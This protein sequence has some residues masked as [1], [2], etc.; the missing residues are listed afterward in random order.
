MPLLP[1]RAVA[2]CQAAPRALKWKAPQGFLPVGW[3][4]RWRGGRGLSFNLA[5]L[6]PLVLLKEARWRQLSTPAT[7]GGSPCLLTVERGGGRKSTV[8]GSRF[9]SAPSALWNWSFAFFFFRTPRRRTASLKGNEVSCVPHGAWGTEIIKAMRFPGSSQCLRWVLIWGRRARS[10]D[11]FQSA[12]ILYLSVR[13]MSAGP[14]GHAR[15]GVRIAVGAGSGL[16]VSCVV[17]YLFVS[18]RESAWF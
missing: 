3:C 7:A 17:A 12:S 18:E 9:L 15:L 8:L 5:C 13:Q 14:G 6:L 4:P 2:S 11:R 1:Q 16:R 10:E